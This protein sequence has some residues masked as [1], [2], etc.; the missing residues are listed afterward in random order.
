[1]CREGAHWMCTPIG[2]ASAHCLWALPTLHSW[3]TLNVCAGIV[4]WL[5]CQ[6]RV[7]V[8]IANMHLRV[9]IFS[10]APAYCRPQGQSRPVDTARLQAFATTCILCLD[11]STTSLQVEH[12]LIVNTYCNICTN[13]NKRN[14]HNDIVHWQ[15]TLPV[16]TGQHTLTAH[17][18][19]TT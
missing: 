16:R 1:M 18:G 5:R 11:L 19:N 4:P 13:A 12:C 14:A 2:A 3:C 9:L 10:F 15:C 17:T 6:V 7:V 8:C